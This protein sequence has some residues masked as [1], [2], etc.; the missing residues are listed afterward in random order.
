MLSPHV[1]RNGVCGEK[2]ITI[3]FCVQIAIFLKGEEV[4]ARLHETPM[5]KKKEM[6]RVI[7]NHI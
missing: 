7:N 6:A 1:V 5:R 4:T 3:L 2:G